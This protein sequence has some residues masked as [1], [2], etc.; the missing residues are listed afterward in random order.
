MGADCIVKEYRIKPFIAT[1]S[2]CN[3]GTGGKSFVA[4]SACGLWLWQ[5]ICQTEGGMQSSVEP[6]GLQI[7]EVQCHHAWRQGRKMADSVRTG[8]G[9]RTLRER[10]E[11]RRMLFQQLG[12]GEA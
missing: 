6:E 8:L 2:Q 7:P 4:N 5:S 10:I 11:M 12:L 3:F 9:R 1:T